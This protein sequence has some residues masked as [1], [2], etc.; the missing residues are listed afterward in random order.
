MLLV[1]AAEGFLDLPRGLLEANA[2][3]EEENTFQPAD[4]VPG[5]SPEE[6]EGESTPLYAC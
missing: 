3:G 2:A 4:Q 6:H 1:N 5:A